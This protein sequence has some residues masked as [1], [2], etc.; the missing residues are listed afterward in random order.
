MVGGLFVGF[1]E[2]CSIYPTYLVTFYPLKVVEN[3]QNKVAKLV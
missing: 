1:V 2:F 3:F